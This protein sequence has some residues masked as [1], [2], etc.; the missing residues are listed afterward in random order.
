VNLLS[1]ILTRASGMSTYDFAEK[2]LFPPLKISVRSWLRDPQGIYAGGTGMMF[3]PR[4]Q[5][6]VNE[7]VII[8]IAKKY[9][10]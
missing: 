8:G 7:A 6:N 10:F 3:T 4:D 1:G 2:Y 5:V 9:F